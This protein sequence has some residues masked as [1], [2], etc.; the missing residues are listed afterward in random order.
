[1]LVRYSDPIRL[2]QFPG[3]CGKGHDAGI[4]NAWL[5]ELLSG[6]EEATIATWSKLGMESN[7][8]LVNTS[9][10]PI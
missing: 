4:M 2:S 7:Y 1:M 9:R 6:I 3:G 10:S 8:I 5:E